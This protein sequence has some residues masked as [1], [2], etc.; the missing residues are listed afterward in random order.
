MSFDELEQ[1]N[2][3]FGE[4]IEEASDTLTQGE[5][6]AGEPMQLEDVHPQPSP[7]LFDRVEPPDAGRQPHRLD[8]RIRPS[9]FRHVGNPI[10]S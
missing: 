5:E 1:T 3:T 7:R 4:L 2:G 6:I 10:P 9:R 8:L